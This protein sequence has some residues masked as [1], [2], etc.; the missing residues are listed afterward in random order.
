M[1]VVKK[2]KNQGPLKA[3]HKWWRFIVKRKTKNN[4]RYLKLAIK[5]DTVICAIGQANPC[6]KTDARLFHLPSSFYR[7]TSKTANLVLGMAK[8]PS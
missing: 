3:N 2:E 8:K 4:F 5:R 7:I 1:W 6:V